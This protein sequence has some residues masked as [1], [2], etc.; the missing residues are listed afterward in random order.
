MNLRTKLW[1]LIVTS[2]I[3]GFL[4]LF[5]II[6][7]MGALFNK[8]YTH[9]SLNQIGTSFTAKA[10]QLEN[11]P[12]QVKSLI[13]RYA[14]EHPDLR[15]EW[16]G[17]DGTLRY[18]S[19][20]RT[21][22]YSF[23]EWSNRFLNM[24]FSLWESDQ[25][26]TLV[27]TWGQT[28]HSQYLYLSLPSEAMQGNQVYLYIRNNIAMLQL[29]IPIVL[30]LVTPYIFALF[31]F[32][33]INR[34]LKKLNQAMNQIDA[35][36]SMVALEDR[37]ND[38]IGQLTR[39]FN[40]MSKRISDQVSQIQEFETKRKT[41]IANISHDL[42]TPLTMIQGYAETLHSGMV[43][44][45]EEKKSYIEII[46]RRSRYMDQLLQKLF[47]I[48]RLDTHKDRIRL[49]KVN[50]S[51][52]LRRIAADYVR[53][54][55]SRGMEFDIQIPE[56]AI[57]SR[58]DSHLFERA[59]RNLIE[60]AIQYG[61]AGVYLGLALEMNRDQLEIKIIDRG[62]GIPEEQQR[63]IFERFYRGSDGR[64]GE[65]IGIGLSIV[66]EIAAAHEGSVQLQSIPYEQTAFSL[67]LPCRG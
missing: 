64:E 46:L 52:Q 7:I 60:N 34:R 47:E 33:R 25:T 22:P 57:Y 37:S 28:D 66:K 40:S 21:R 45:E 31:F 43:Q 14:K 49:E 63:R 67:I 24:P 18:D 11:Q 59:V 15:L 39:H 51:E 65:G 54:L 6:L 36:G 38:E 4:L 29:L 5:G 13:D 55:E 1:L 27:F 2:T 58:I 10:E 30:F 12:D 42:R 41:L 56:R 20:G 53:V 19:D 9:G 62:P 16:F 50:C 26:I 8:G 17:H 3:A 32:G 48:S 61:S 23:D 35:Q 44:G